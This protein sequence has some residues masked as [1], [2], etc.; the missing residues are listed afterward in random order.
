MISY[1]IKE[2]IR[3]KTINRMLFNRELKKFEID[4]RVL[5][6]GAGT[7]RSSYLNFLK[8]GKEV[9]IASIDISQERKPDIVGNLEEAL[10]VKDNEFDNILCFN[11]LEH[12]FNYQNLINESF[13]VLKR[14]GQIIGYVPF[15]VKFHPDPNDY[16]RYSRQSL[17]KILSR[18]GF[19]GVKTIFIG[20]GP[21]TA[22]WSQIEYFLPKYVRWLATLLIFALDNVILKLKPVF[23]E[24]YP[25]GYI[26]SAQK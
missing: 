2:T 16:F 21:V 10:P 12:I 18:S 24:K 13:R 19:H 22:A 17:V 8:V 15:L 23:K 26:F 7:K 25:L 14:G 20:R 6:L 3:G 5:D 4:G 1:I 11:L 9:A